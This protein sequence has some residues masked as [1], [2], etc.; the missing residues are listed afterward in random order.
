MKIYTR[1]LFFFL[2]SVKFEPGWLWANFL[3]ESEAPEFL[4][5]P[6]NCNDY[7]GLMWAILICLVQLS[8]P[9]LVLHPL[10]YSDDR[11][12]VTPNLDE[13]HASDT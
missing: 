11:Q 12:F 1:N 3:T 6:S 7:L 9:G 13:S 8:D 10:L 5:C 4:G 2:V